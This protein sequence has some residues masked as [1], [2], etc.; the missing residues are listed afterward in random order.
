MRD[1]VRTISDCRA[2]DGGLGVQVFAFRLQLL[3]VACRATAAGQVRLTCNLSER[4]RR[5][6]LIICNEISKLINF[7]KMRVLN[8]VFG[9]EYKDGHDKLKIL[10]DK[11]QEKRR[12]SEKAGQS[13]ICLAAWSQ[14]QIHTFQLCQGKKLKREDSPAD[15]ICSFKQGGCS[16]SWLDEDWEDLDFFKE[17]HCLRRSEG[18]S[19]V[20]ALIVPASQA[21]EFLP[22]QP[23]FKL[24]QNTMGLR[25]W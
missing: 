15:M 3:P 1:F 21:F 17:C 13:V 7:S 5:T 24:L 22:V 14:K 11:E 8:K 16:S 20:E 23:W 4:R 2:E 6:L 25:P 12:S 10:S 9:L 19:A 18:G